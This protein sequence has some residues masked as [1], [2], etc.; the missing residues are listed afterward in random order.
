V[1]FVEHRM[2]TSPYR[3]GKLELRNRLVMAPM[4]SR[5][6]DQH[7][8]V[9]Q[10]LIDYYAARAQ[11]G[12]GLIV[13]EY[14]YIDAKASHAYIGQLGIYDDLLVAGLG[15]L[16]EAIHEEG[17][18]ALIQIN[19]AGRCTTTGITGRQP[20]APSA[21]WNLVGTELT[22]EMTAAEIEEIKDAYAAA[23]YRAK[24]AGFD[25]I[26]L[27][28]TH[29]YLLAQFYSPHFNQRADLY[30]QDRALFPVEVVQ[31]V[32][33]RVGSDFIL[34]YRMTGEEYIPDGITPDSAQL[35]ARRLEAAGVDYL[36]VSA[37]L[38]ETIEDFLPPVYCPA[39]ALVPLAEKVRSVVQVPVV[40]V[41]AIHDPDL[42]EEVLVQGKA[43]LI[44][45]GRALIADAELPAKIVAGRPETIRPC[46]RCNEGCSNRAYPFLTQ[47][48][49]VNPEVGRERDLRITP[50]AT[51][52]RVCVVGG[53][54]GGMEAASTLAARG[55][56]VTLIEKEAELGGL[57]RF[58]AVPAFK[59][60]LR[61]YLDYLK[62]EVARQG[63]ELLLSQTATLEW[64][65]A[66]SPDAVVVATG[67]SFKDPGI[68]G[69]DQ[70]GVAWATEILAAQELA[71]EKVLVV[72]GSAM[73]CELALHLWGQGKTV[74]LV[75]MLDE[76]AVDLFGVVRP[77]LLHLLGASGVQILTGHRLLEIGPG[78]ATMS[79]PDHLPVE[80]AAD[81]VA[82][83]FGLAPNTELATQLAGTVDRIYT[84]GDCVAPRKI[85]DAIHE[86]AFVGRRI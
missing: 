57:L 16:A 31:T 5:L 15:D 37:G 51:S 42:A 23:A 67:S 55:H 64:I 24:L 10:K 18:K 68:K 62:G 25:G 47:R 74:T 71:G 56:K 34:G 21:C 40:A 6:C 48:C 79:G 14:S 83:A 41:G 82:L 28:G 44:A 60:E 45:L 13:V 61:T 72:G 69:A 4:L 38:Q 73:G 33:K 86:A 59:K 22:R 7:G 75:E 53:G 19:H 70:P 30:G 65:R 49:A 77:A 52:Q 43:D 63:V 76:L 8:A 36:H 81:T 58:A 9:T 12:V 39:G 1:I 29:G 11:G 26:E 80:I 66:L 2:L 54:P 27:H 3:L 35:L 46:V 50:A 20:I 17:A 32:R 78:G 85:Y 84:I